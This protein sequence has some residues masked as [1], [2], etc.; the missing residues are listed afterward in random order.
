MTV[1]ELKEYIADLPDNMDVMIMQ[2]NDDFRYNLLQNS[3]VKEVNFID[4]SNK[5]VYAFEAC[6]ILSDEIIDSND[7]DSDP[8]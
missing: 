1:K 7:Y 5:E 3:E 6:L 2:V 4:P 8:N